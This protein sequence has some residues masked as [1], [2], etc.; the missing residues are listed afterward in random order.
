MMTLSQLESDSK[1][2]LDSFPHQCTV[3]T[4]THQTM[5]SREHDS[6]DQKIHPSN[7]S[8]FVGKADVFDFHPE[9]YDNRKYEAL[10]EV[11]RDDSQT[12]SNFIRTQEE[13][14]T[15]AGVGLRHRSL[16]RDG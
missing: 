2:R 4:G 1:V 10:S 15:A 5:I 12:V 9:L 3:E 16:L 13:S 7:L 8:E 11:E 6:F 14:L